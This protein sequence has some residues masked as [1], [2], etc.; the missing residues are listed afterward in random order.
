MFDV[1]VIGGGVGGYVAAIRC[2]QL[3]LKVALIEQR[4]DERL[5]GTC[6]NE[7]CIPAKALLESA[8]AYQSINNEFK[9]LGIIAERV[10]IDVEQIFKRKNEVIEKLTAGVRQ[11]ITANKIE[12]F[13]GQGKLKSGKC[14]ELLKN[15][16][17]K[18][19]LSAKNIILSLGSVPVD[20]KSAPQDGKFIISSTEAL[21]LG[22]IPKSLGIIGSG[23]IGLELGSVYNDLG[24]EVEIFEALPEFLPNFDKKL[25]KEALKN[26]LNQ[27]LKINLNSVVKNAEIIGEKVKISVE[28]AGIL[29]EKVFD[30]LLVCVGRKPNTPKEV[31]NGIVQTNQRGFIVVNEFC[32]TTEPNVYAIGDCA[33]G[34]MLAHKAAEE[35]IMV[36]ERIVG[37][38][39]SMRRDLIPS[40]I[41][42]R[43]EIAAV[44]KSEE[45]LQALGIAYKVGDF[46][47]A[48]NG[49]ALAAAET[50]GFCKILT[51]KDTDEILGAQIFGKN[52]SELIAELVLAMNFY[53][54][55]EDIALTIHAHPTLS[56]I[57][58][59]AALDTLGMGL[60]KI[61][62]V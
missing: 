36:A 41:Y 47:F 8:H 14:V 34:M 61:S 4:A 27:G 56:E 32:E 7:G 51:D 38:N 60:H 42:T 35:A 3:G 33:G 50:A 15:N 23:V 48:A 5:G 25:S 6:L 10:S 62:K 43:P 52:A 22:E 54:S 55:A 1:I 40:I 24:A 11:L 49:R 16:G 26:F 30:K 58:H 53:A 13:L 12:L 44:G 28:L 9:N 17:E 2:A 31:L 20:I 46:N 18:A 19:E 39:S 29:Q 21:N 59:E 57:I 37:E 45:E